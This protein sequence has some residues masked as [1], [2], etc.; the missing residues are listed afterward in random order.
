M[1]WRDGEHT[2]EDAITEARRIGFF[3]VH[4][5]TN[6]TLGLKSSADLTWVSMDG[7]P[8]TFELR[9]GDHFHQVEHAVREEGAHAKIAILYVIDRNTMDGIEPFLRWVHDTRFPC[10]RGHVLLSHTLLRV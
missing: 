6:G 7:L 9:R 10:N 5:Y 4:V 8:G 1:L 2:L 3:H